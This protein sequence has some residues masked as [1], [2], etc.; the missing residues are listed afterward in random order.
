MHQ[1][2]GWGVHAPWQL[3]HSLLP[4]LGLCPPTPPLQHLSMSKHFPIHLLCFLAMM[5]EAVVNIHTRGHSW[6]LD[7][8]LQTAL[9]GG[10]DEARP[11]EEDTR[12]LR[13]KTLALRATARKRQCWASGSRV[14]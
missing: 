10:G 6:S 8:T 12:A 7:C 4:S 9:T 13:G 3:P 2:L 1:G 5:H 11:T 14:L